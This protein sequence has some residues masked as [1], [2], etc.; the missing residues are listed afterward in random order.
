M[1][2]KEWNNFK[3]GDWSKGI[4]VRDFII[5]NY[6]PYLGDESFL[7]GPTEATSKLWSRVLEFY[8]EEKEHGGVLDI[9][10]DTIS[11]ISAHAPGYIDSYRSHE[12]A[13]DPLD[14]WHGPCGN[15]HSEQS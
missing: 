7:E 2:F 15:C 13:S 9:D 8:K 3:L 12:G 11:T 4:H 6:T 1:E 5:S 10:T 14:R